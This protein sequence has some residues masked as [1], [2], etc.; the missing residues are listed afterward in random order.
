MV[1]TFMEAVDAIMKKIPFIRI[2]YWNFLIWKFEKESGMPLI[3]AF[4]NDFLTE[5]VEE[6]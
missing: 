2:L 6:I 5:E 1:V 3:L 4:A